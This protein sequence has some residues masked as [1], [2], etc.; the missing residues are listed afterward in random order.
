MLPVIL[1]CLSLSLISGFYGEPIMIDDIGMLA[2][3]PALQYTD[4]DVMDGT[5]LN[6][7]IIRAAQPRDAWDELEVERCFTK[8]GVIRTSIFNAAGV[9]LNT[10]YVSVEDVPPHVILLKKRPSGL[11]FIQIETK[12]DRTPKK[13]FI[14]Q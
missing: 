3:Q 10:V 2:S 6:F 1:A 13:A 4:A 7:R 12:T 5:V 9:H 14:V 8:G 11:Y